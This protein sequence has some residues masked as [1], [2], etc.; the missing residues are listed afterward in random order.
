MIPSLNLIHKPDYGATS[1]TSSSHNGCSNDGR[2]SVLVNLDY[3]LDQKDHIGLQARK[4]HWFLLLVFFMFGLIV[5]EVTPGVSLSALKTKC[6]RSVLSDSTGEP[7][8]YILRQDHPTS[9]IC[10]VEKFSRSSQ[11][12]KSLLLLRHAKSSWESSFFVDDI[13]RHLSKKGIAVAHAVGRSLNDMNVKLPDLILSSPSVRTEETLNIV[14][15]EWILGAESHKYPKFSLHFKGESEKQHD[16]LNEKLEENNVKIQYSDALYSLSDEGYLHHLVAVLRNSSHFNQ[17]YEPV[18]VL[19]VGHNPAM[20]ELLNYLLPRRLNLA[21]A[22]LDNSHRHFAPG[23]F[24]EI[25]F[26]G[27]GSWGDLEQTTM[28]DRI[29]ILSLLLPLHK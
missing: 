18:R 2:R 10:T 7:S 20:E 9:C 15:G 13:D 8:A 3:S 27:L 28:K 11:Y 29:G 12:C 6:F 4:F 1:T 5:T 26:P 14:M 23:Q 25:C 24:Y 21:D 17:S 16:E 19:I 22:T